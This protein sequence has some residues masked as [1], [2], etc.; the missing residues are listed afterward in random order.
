MQSAHFR[1]VK[2]TLTDLHRETKKV[3]RPVL[4]GKPVAITE[5]GA[6]VARITPDYERVTLSEDEFRSLEITDQAILRALAESRE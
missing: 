5:H 1:T 2:A 3:M 4:G 6:P